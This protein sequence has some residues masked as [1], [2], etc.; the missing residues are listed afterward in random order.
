MKKI[1]TLMLLAVSL[2]LSSCGNSY[3][4]MAKKSDKVNVQVTPEVLALN[5]NKIPV[6]LMMEFPAKYFAKDAQVRITPVL[7]SESKDMAAKPFVLQGSDV[8]KNNK[9]VDWTK[10]AT[11]REK[12]SFTYSNDFRNCE[13]Y[14]RFEIMDGDKFVLANAQ[15]GKT[16]SA[17]DQ[18]ILAEKPRSA[19]AKTI[20]RENGV[21]VAK[22]VNTLQADMNY[23]HLMQNMPDDFKRIVTTIEKS[24]IRFDINS[25][26]VTAST[27]SNESVKHI[28]ALVGKANANEIFIASGFASPE[29]NTKFN[30]QLAKNRAESSKKA[31]QDLL[32][33]H[34]VKVSTVSYGEDWDGFKELVLNSKMKDKALILQVLSMYDSSKQREAEIRNLSHV[35]T[36]L[37][38]EI[39]P[40]LRRTQ[41]TKRSDDTG[42]SNAQ[43]IAA[44]RSKKHA[45][46]DVNEILYICD[47]LNVTVKE[48]IMLLEFAAAKFNDARAYNNLGVVQAKAGNLDAAKTAFDSAVEKGA[49]GVEITKNQVLINL[50]IG[51]TTAAK[52]LAQGADDVAKAA[53]AANEGNYVPATR[54]M[55]GYNVAIAYTQVGNYAAAKKALANVHT[56]DADYL[57]ACVAT[58]QGDLKTAGTSL[59][60]AVRKQRSL[61]T[62]AQ[63]DI[64]LRPLFRSGFTL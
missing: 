58:K 22:G 7:I 59:Q 52:R 23:S 2:T 3:T 24:D 60:S 31:V 35:F 48:K 47:D 57:R 53:V 46:L 15:T 41:I 45:T 19:E 44:V 55:I 54:N 32:K 21:A 63:N 18:K 37:K 16:I 8:E 51:N 49:K 14:L 9:T 6:E 62:K 39:L 13:L 10:G 64:N 1:F 36:E 34:N 30:Q 33:E 29:G 43:L 5:N 20:L 4:K 12:F 11:V 28:K 50:M 27:L 17:E 40:L 25:S 61:R 42:K 26:K 56:A 38:T